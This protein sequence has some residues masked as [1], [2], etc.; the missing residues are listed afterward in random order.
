MNSNGSA[1]SARRLRAAAATAIAVAAACTMAAAGCASSAPRP[2]ASPAPSGAT[3]GFPD[4]AAG[5]QARWLLGAVPH[6]PIPA[7]AIRTHFDATF[8]AQVPASRLNSVL[9]AVRSLRLDS[10]T[11]STPG[12]LA[13]VVTANGASRLTVNMATDTRGM[14]LAPSRWR[15]AW[16]K[17]G[18]EPGVLT[19]N[20]LATTRT[21]RTYVASVLA[22]NPA[23]PLAPDSATL[24]LISA[25]KDALQL[26]AG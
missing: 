20:Y 5:R 13:F 6:A 15:P 8:L 7:A 11:H 14:N 4:T 9:A 1:R 12:S 19:L 3:A 23:A 17:G 24:T 10:I 25:V 22:A 26:A 21:G 16:F 18:S 2:A